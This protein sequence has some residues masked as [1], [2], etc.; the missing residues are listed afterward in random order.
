MFEQDLPVAGGRIVIGVGDQLAHEERI[1]R[2]VL[3]QQHAQ[4]PRI[5]HGVAVCHRRGGSVTHPPL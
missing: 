3:D 5:R 2:I 4:G 1:R